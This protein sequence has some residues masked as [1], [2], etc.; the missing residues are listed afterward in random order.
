M[1]AFI[2]AL[3]VLAILAHAGLLALYVWYGQIAYRLS[4]QDLSLQMMRDEIARL[5]KLVTGKKDR[6]DIIPR[7]PVQPKKAN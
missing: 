6:M 5:E 7:P 4:R 3:Y 2:V 1:F